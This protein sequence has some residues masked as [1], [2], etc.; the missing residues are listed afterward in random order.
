MKNLGLKY[1]TL[2]IVLVPLVLTSLG[3]L[4]YQTSFIHKNFQKQED[5]RVHKLANFIS[6]TIAIA[7]WNFQTDVIKTVCHDV[8][9][10]ND[11]KEIVITDKNNNPVYSIAFDSKGFTSEKDPQRQGRSIS[12]PIIQ[13]TDTIG[14]IEVFYDYAYI[15]QIIKKLT[16]TQGILL[17]IQFILVLTFFYLALELGIV[18]PVKRVKNALHEISEGDGDLSRRLDVKT[19]DEIGELSQSFNTFVNKIDELA[20]SIRVSSSELTASATE[21][22]TGNTQISESTQEMASALEQTAASMEEITSSI[23]HNADMSADAA[24]EI[25]DV[26]QNAQDGAVLLNKMD[27]A[28]ETVSTSSEKIGKIVSV[29]NEIAFQTNLLALN[30]AVEAARAGEHGKGFAVVANEV[31]ELAGRSADAVAEIKRIVEDNRDH[32]E[33]TGNLSKNTTG[34]LTKVVER[35]QKSSQSIEDIVTRAQEQALTAKEINQAV[36]T[37]DDATQKNAAVLEQL[38]SAAQNMSDLSQNLEKRAEQF[39]VTGE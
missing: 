30:A 4:V 31:R 29:V 1:K 14:E 10:H 13:E 7:L 21:V 5:A 12:V 2:L 26:S 6:P 28:M 16:S 17:V 8:I 39:K 34:I 19:N 3:I 35:I 27:S 36:I 38:T 22:S 33:N 24:I 11:L 15:N 18:R 20:G 9:Q 37:M 25:K 32:I 23:Q